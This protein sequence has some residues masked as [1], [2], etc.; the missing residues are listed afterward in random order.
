MSVRAQSL[1]TSYLGVIDD[2]SATGL[3]PAGL[4]LMNRREFSLAFGFQSRNQTLSYFSNTSES[5]DHSLIP[6]FFAYASPFSF[7]GTKGGYGLTF[8][9]DEDYRASGTFGAFNSTSSIVQSLLREANSNTDNLPYQTYLADTVNG[10]LFSPLRDSVFQ[11]ATLHQDG[12]RYSLLFGVGVDL[13]KDV[14]L[15]LSLGSSWSQYNYQRSYS[16][17]DTYNKYDTLDRANFSTVDF[18]KLSLVDHLDQQTAAF[19]IKLGMLARLSEWGRLSLSVS[20]PMAHVV[21]EVWDRSMAVYYDNDTTSPF[22]AT[23]NGQSDYVVYSPW[24]FGFGLSGH[25]LGLTLSAG[26]SYRDYVSASFSNDYSF[27]NELNDSVRTQLRDQ[28]TYSVGA[29]YRIPATSLFIR[30][31]MDNTSSAFVSTVSSTTTTQVAG[32]LG[33]VLGDKQNMRLDFMLRSGSTKGNF[34]VYGDGSE[35]SYSQSTST[36]QYA[37]QFSYRY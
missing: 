16:E 6:S 37:L 12:G 7:G 13:G 19:F 22:S 11:R 30:A 18:H 36:L 8:S 20:P 26:A 28:L 33:I 35:A 5:N 2:A 9:T 10:R 24:E 17:A 34:A 14:A 25:F 29:E 21:H 23:Q 27:L 32:G 31:S 4:A 3:N 15:G 1:G